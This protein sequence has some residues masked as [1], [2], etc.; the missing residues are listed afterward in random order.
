MR[1]NLTELKKFLESKDIPVITIDQ[2]RSGHYRIRLP[3]NRHVFFSSS[4]SD[5]RARR[6]LVSKIRRLT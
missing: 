3:G 5:Y 1:K 2:A 6:N 4:P